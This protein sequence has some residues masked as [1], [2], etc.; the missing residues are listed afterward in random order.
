MIIPVQTAGV[1]LAVVCF[2]KGKLMTGA[3]GL[4]VPIV[5]V[6]GALRPAKPGSPWERRGRTVAT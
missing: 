4:F 5:S 6:V 3:V 1:C 2:A